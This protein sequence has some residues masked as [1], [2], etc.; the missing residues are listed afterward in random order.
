MGTYG[1]DYDRRAI[2]AHG[3]LGANLPAD[4]IYPN[5]RVDATGAMLNSDRNYV[6]H[7]AADQIPPV[8]AFR[9][10]T[11]YNDKGFFVAN[12]IDRFAVR[13]EQMRKNPDGSLDIYIQRENPGPEKESNWLPGPAT[14]DFN[15]MQRL[16]WPDTKI[17]GGTW[18]PPAVTAAP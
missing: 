18:T 14:G 5:T 17:I 16:Y 8:Y 11:M 9:S 2:V 15:L 13:G 12:P 4:A 6:L 1:T 10:L 7:F 3:G